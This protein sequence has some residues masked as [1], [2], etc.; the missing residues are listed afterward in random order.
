[1]RLD[2]LL[3]VLRCCGASAD[4]RQIDR[5]NLGLQSCPSHRQLAI[6]TWQSL[7]MT[8]YMHVHGCIQ[9]IATDCP[10][11]TVLPVRW[12]RLKEIHAYS[13]VP[14][15]R[16]LHVRRLCRTF[17]KLRERNLK[18]PFETSINHDRP[19]NVDRP[20]HLHKLSTI[21]RSD[22]RSVC[23]TLIVMSKAGLSTRAT[24]N[25]PSTSVVTP[26]SARRRS[27]QCSP[28]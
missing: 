9:S 4:V 7:L 25:Y 28:R 16:K 18:P 21:G 20:P 26:S 6:A 11:R 3:S 5:G 17:G 14:L 15:E 19:M 10:Y 8:V 22:A 27:Y 23:A 13:R 1:M 12:T 24:A 2:Y